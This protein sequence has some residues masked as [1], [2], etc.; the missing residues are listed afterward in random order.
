MSTIVAIYA[1]SAE[2]ELFS[3]SPLDIPARSRWGAT[4]LAQ[5]ISS[6]IAGAQSCASI[7]LD[8][9]VDPESPIN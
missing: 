2:C 3:L 6:D 7:F 5:N 4:E 9:A 1:A 8:R